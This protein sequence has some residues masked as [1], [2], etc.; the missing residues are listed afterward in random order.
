MDY[1]TNLSSL[2][3]EALT[4]SSICDLLLAKT[5]FSSRSIPASEWWHCK[6]CSSISSG[7][8]SSDMAFCLRRS[9]PCHRPC[10]RG[11]PGLAGAAR[12]WPAVV[13]ARARKCSAHVRVHVHARAR[14][15]Y[16]ARRRAGRRGAHG[17]RCSFLNRTNQ[18]AAINTCHI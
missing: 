13:R 9:V 14:I 7:T 3:R 17:A 10:A 2:T 1:T 8:E 4:L 6:H 11:R 5:G 12:A 16:C 18:L 15:A